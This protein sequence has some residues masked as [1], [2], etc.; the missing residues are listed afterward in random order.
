MALR[1]AQGHV[2]VSH[3]DY[4]CTVGGGEMAVLAL[5]PLFT[6]LFHFSY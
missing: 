6:L 5:S 3:L 4:N 2:P 1:R